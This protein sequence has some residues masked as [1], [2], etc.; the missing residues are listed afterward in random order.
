MLCKP[1][2]EKATHQCPL[3]ANHDDC[4]FQHVKVLCADTAD[5]FHPDGLN[6]RNWRIVEMKPVEV[7]L[8]SCGQ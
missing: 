4:R 8:V 7:E 2:R 3:T 1:W 6:L 5:T